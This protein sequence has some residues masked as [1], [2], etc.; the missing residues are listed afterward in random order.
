M[1][2]RFGIFGAV[3]RIRELIL[4][5]VVTLRIPNTRHPA[6]GALGVS[7]STP[8][9]VVSREQGASPAASAQLCHQSA[10]RRPLQA[11]LMSLPP[12]PPVPA[13]TRGG[14]GARSSLMPH[15]PVVPWVKVARIPV[16]ARSS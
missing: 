16:V 8:S 15:L 7:L 12:R 1:R 14:Y 2:D 10:A 13:T 11:P 5:L 4:L 3:I 9:P 6:V